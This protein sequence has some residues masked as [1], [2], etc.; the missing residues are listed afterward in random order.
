M[1][2]DVKPKQPPVNPQGE[3]TAHAAHGGHEPD[4]VSGRGIFMFMGLL[5]VTV[6]ITYLGI[7]WMYD[8]FQADAEQAE[9]P[10][11]PLAGERLKEP[12]GPRLQVDEHIDLAELRKAENERLTSYAWLNEHDKLARIPID[13]AMELVVKTGLPKWPPVKPDGP[14]PEDKKK[15]AN[16]EADKP[17]AETKP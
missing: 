7:A 2:E 10:A 11:S 3:E 15:S 1:N 17:A 13:R 9:P 16:P 6:V 14:V 8:N 12:A 4:V 5:V